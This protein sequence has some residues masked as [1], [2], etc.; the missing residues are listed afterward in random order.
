MLLNENSGLATWT[1]SDEHMGICTIQFAV[2]DEDGLTSYQDVVLQVVPFFN[3]QPQ[4][5]S[6][7]VL[8]VQEDS[9]YAYPAEATD[10][11]NN[12]LTFFLVNGPPG[13][14]M[15]ESGL[16]SWNPPNEYVGSHP[17]TIAV[18]DTYDTTRQ[19]FVVTVTNTND[20]PGITSTPPLSAVIGA[21][22]TYQ[23]AAVD[24]DNDDLSYTL[25]ESPAGMTIDQSGLIVWPDDGNRQDGV[26]VE[27]S[28]GDDSGATALQDWTISLAEDDEPPVISITV[29]P[30]VAAPNEQVI[31]GVACFDN[32]NVASVSLEC[33]G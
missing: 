20:Q 31:V 28:V 21:A 18:T 17:V 25:I 4:F 12:E 13:M 9:D 5:T 11:D 27:V 8:A 15:S 7:P 16:L 33:D 32:V 24:A 30:P 6:D 1:T 2:F 14:D 23:V 19:A 29:D 22:Y 3:N 26:P 10:A